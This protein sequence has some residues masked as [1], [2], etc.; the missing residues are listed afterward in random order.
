L[1]AS[2][3]YKLARDTGDP[4][5]DASF[6]ELYKQSVDRNEDGNWDPGEGL[7]PMVRVLDIMAGQNGYPAYFTYRPMTNWQR[8]LHANVVLA[9][10]CD[11]FGASE[12]AEFKKEN[13]PF[14]EATF[15]QARDYAVM[16]WFYFAAKD[17]VVREAWQTMKDR[18]EDEAI[19]HFEDILEE[20]REKFGEHL[21]PHLAYPLCKPDR[22]YDSDDW[23]QFLGVELVHE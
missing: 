13:V 5:R 11:P 19:A 6:R 8:H 14:G 1:N 10:T 4:A 15:E 17:K 9:W 12:P 22:Y 23:E 3:L 20:L 18:Y 16:E 7:N 2:D 21:V